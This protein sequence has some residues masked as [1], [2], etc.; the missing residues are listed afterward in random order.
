MSVIFCLQKKSMTY[1]MQMS[2]G[3]VP[4]LAVTRAI[5]EANV[6]KILSWSV[7]AALAW[8]GYVIEVEERNLAR[9]AWSSIELAIPDRIMR[10]GK[11]SE[12]CAL[13][14]RSRRSVSRCG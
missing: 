1:I 5:I 3:R 9:R 10:L 11:R 12:R 14:D 13:R 6:Q 8:S 7:I 2:S 4:A